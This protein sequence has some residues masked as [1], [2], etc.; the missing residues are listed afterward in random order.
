MTNLTAAEYKAQ[1]DACRKKYIA[2]STVRLDCAVAWDQIA[3]V[4]SMLWRGQ[5]EFEDNDFTPS[6]AALAYR[7]DAENLLNNAKGRLV[8]PLSISSP[9][10]TASASWA[11]T[12]AYDYLEMAKREARQAAEGQV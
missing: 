11:S 8:G 7:T 10:A 12:M 2:G 4:Y 6:T 5:Q 9:S 3:G 1:V